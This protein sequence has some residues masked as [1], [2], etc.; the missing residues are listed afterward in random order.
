MH[1]IKG[2]HA[3]QYLGRI[4]RH[5]GKR[6]NEESPLLERHAV[7]FPIR[8][9]EVDEVNAHRNQLQSIDRPAA[10]KMVAHKRE[11]E[12]LSMSQT[13]KIALK[14]RTPANVHNN[15]PGKSRQR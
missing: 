6:F 11:G 14:Q 3:I 10:K 8:E 7:A 4:V 9:E 12:L 15:V 1:K 5:R 2:C 13:T